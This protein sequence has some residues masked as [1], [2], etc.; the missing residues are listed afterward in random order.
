M[1]LDL[2]FVAVGLVLLT[3]A[4]D[5]FVIGAARIALVMQ[6]SA[7]VVGAVIVGFGTSA[8]EMLVSGVA[9]WQGDAEVGVGNIVGS[10]VANLTLVLGAAVLIVPIAIAG[11]TVRKETPLMV[12]S[13]L[14][15]AWFVQGGVTVVEAAILL[16]VLFG[17]LFLLI[18]TGGVSPDPDLEREVAEFTD[19][20][21]MPRLRTEVVRT[22][23]G[24][25]GTLIGAQLLVSGAV[26]I[27]EEFGLS[28]GFV[29]FTLVA[30]GTSL[31]ELVTAVAAARAGEPDLIVGNLLGS[32]LFNSLAVGAVLVMAG[33][34]DFDSPRLLSVGV[35]A[36]VAV[37]VGVWVVMITRRKIVRWEG[38][39]LLVVYI[40]AVA[41]IGPGG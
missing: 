21:H 33:T 8:P 28:G 19:R 37:A 24:L 1:I 2:V 34:S 6:V 15:F 39:V 22:I 18:K 38:A 5:Q 14:L 16:V 9:A 17:S 40:G 11:S 23:V 26:D 10:N 41:L 29:G 20:A 13:V 27:A 12:M 36:M 32:N 7:V 4:A 35:L 30:I 31:P 3:K 25:I